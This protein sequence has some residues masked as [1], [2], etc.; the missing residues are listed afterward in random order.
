MNAPM[1]VQ[2]LPVVENSRTEITAIQIVTRVHGPHVL[3][4]RFPMSKTLMASV[5]SMRILGTVIH[6][7]LRIRE[8]LA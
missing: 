8:V 2:V 3:V 4:E 1:G 7:L 5:A 6:G